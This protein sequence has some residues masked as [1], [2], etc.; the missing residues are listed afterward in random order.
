M[1][2]KKLE[3]RELNGQDTFLML[4]IVAKLN[5][6]DVIKFFENERGKHADEE[7]SGD[8]VDEIGIEMAAKALELVLADI[9]KVRKD[10]NKL[11]ASVCD[12]TQKEV[13]GLGF[14]EYNMLIIE[15][16]TQD[17]F[18]GFFKQLYSSLS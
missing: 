5:I 11:L 8:E 18:K 1:T 15:L 3:M 16:F 14:A 13:E 4:P 6:A 2:E 9:G 12:T 17:E 10:I 7:M